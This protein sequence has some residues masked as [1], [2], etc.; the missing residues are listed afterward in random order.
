M[1]A[2]RCPTTCPCNFG[3]DAAAV[4]CEAIVGWHIEDGHYGDTRL[5][6]LNVA[7][8]VLTCVL[9]TVSMAW[10]AM[11]DWERPGLFYFFFGLAQSAANLVS[12]QI[13]KAL[14]HFPE[15]REA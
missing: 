8:V 7:L 13:G 15:C 5:D 10:A 11:R 14:F 4:P 12:N 6:G 1:E 3:S 9:F 2:C